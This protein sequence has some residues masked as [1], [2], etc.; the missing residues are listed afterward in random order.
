MIRTLVGRTRPEAA[1]RDGIGLA[2]LP[3]YSFGRG[4]GRRV[5]SHGSQRRALW[6]ER[7]LTGSRGLGRCQELSDARQPKRGEL[8]SDG[9]GLHLED[10]MA[11]GRGQ[12]V[13][14]KTG[15]GWKAEEGSAGV[16]LRG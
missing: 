6:S 11:R 5:V 15:R 10:Q 2:A 8:G 12:Q 14:R 16:L 7:T 1:A 13:E 3:I 9:R 4:E